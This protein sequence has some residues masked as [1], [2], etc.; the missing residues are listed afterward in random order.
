MSAATLS[1]PDFTSPFAGSKVTFPRL[2]VSEWRKLWSLRSTWWVLGIAVVIMIGFA[3]IFSA[4]FTSFVADNADAQG[5]IAAAGGIPPTTFI[6]A[7]YQFATLVAASLGAIAMTGEHS[8]G[9]IRA[10]LSAA[11][12]RLPVLW[13]KIT[14][15]AVVSFVVIAVSTA[16]AYLVTHPVLANHDITVDLGDGEQLRSLIGVP[17]YVM[18]VAVLAVAVGTL[19]RN[20]PG[21]I[22][23][24]VG[25]FF[26]VPSII[27][28]IAGVT[29]AAWAQNLN[30][31]LP[32]AA[33][34]RIITQV[35]SGAS[36]NGP[37]G[38]G[39]SLPL[40][41]AWQGFGV[42]GL[43]TVVLVAFAALVLKRRD[44]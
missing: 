42:L 25:M 43:Y 44:A 8:T 21:T 3:L 19:V 33:G 31:W 41:D 39:T 38:P 32:S 35:G 12:T 14:V 40:F 30:K 11:P 6:T 28:T 9:M 4:A 26:L 1:R 22:V 5:E 2:L 24:V 10:T 36:V 13:A 23:I 17:L 37:G 29:N 20:T 15:I 27:G 7:G 18:V 16:I 34:E